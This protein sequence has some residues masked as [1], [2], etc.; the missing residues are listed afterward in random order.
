MERGPQISLP[1]REGLENSLTLKYEGAIEDTVNGLSDDE[2]EEL[3]KNGNLIYF[4]E[5]RFGHKILGL[6]QDKLIELTKSV[7]HIHR[8]TQKFTDVSR[9]KGCI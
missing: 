5:T 7:Q 8:F 4:G 9:S 3:A 6:Y 2:K 1:L